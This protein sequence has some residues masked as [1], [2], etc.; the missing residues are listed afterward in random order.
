MQHTM[1]RDVANPNAVA[2]AATPATRLA[3]ELARCSAYALAALLLTGVGTL[4]CRRWAM[5]LQQ[6]LDWPSLLLVGAIAAGAGAAARTL[7]RWPAPAGETWAATGAFDWFVSSC[8]VAWG[9]AVSLSGTCSGGLI[10]FW[11]ILAGEELWAWW[12]ALGLDRRLRSLGT[13]LGAHDDLEAV[14]KRGQAPHILCE[15]DVLQE[16]VRSRQPGGA[17]LLSGWMRVPLAP[18]QRSAAVHL[19]FCPPFVRTP[20][21]TVAQQ[22][23]PA[24]RVK[25]VQVLPF[26]ARLDLKLA[27]AT[28]TSASVLLEIVV[29][30]TP[31]EG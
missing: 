16:F 19:A 27:Q 12:N 3:A 10:F 29:Q 14:R 2:C 28:E 21:I 22:E 31:V 6:P 9:I 1:S 7:F 23:G 11:S 30:A 13:A 5:A 26:G 20:T 8:L 15:T 25:E 4:W 18:G 24:A 17:E